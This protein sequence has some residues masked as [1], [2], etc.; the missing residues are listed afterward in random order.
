MSRSPLCQRFPFLGK[1][2]FLFPIIALGCQPAHSSYLPQLRTSIDPLPPVSIPPSCFGKAKATGDYRKLALIVGVGE[3]KKEGINDLRGPPNDARNIYNLLTR[4]TDKGGYGFPRENVCILLDEQAKTEDFKDAFEQGLIERVGSEKDVALFFYAG[5]GSQ[6]RDCNGDEPDEWDE[7]FMFH[8]ARSG[9]VKDFLDDEFNGLLARLYEKTHNITVILDS[10]N[11]GTAT[12][13]GNIVRRNQ[14]PDDQLACST[15]TAR[16]NGDGGREW[17]PDSFPGVVV[18]TAA[19]DGAQAIERRY[20]GQKGEDVFRGV[21]TDALITA[22]GHVD[23][24]PLTY[25]GIARRI[26]M[27][28]SAQSRQIPYFHGDLGKPV[29]GNTER[30]RPLGW[31]VTQVA[32]ENL[33]LSGPPLPGF[34]PGAELRV[35]DAAATGADTNDPTKLKAAIVIDNFNGINADARITSTIPVNGTVEVGD[36]AVLARVSNEE[37]K[38]SVRLRPLTE[39]NGI[40]MTDAER[41]RKTIEEDPEAAMLVTLA[42]AKGSDNFE[43]GRNIDGKWVLFG[44][45]NTVCRTF[46]HRWEIPRNLWQHARQKALKQLEGEGGDDF[47]DNET[48]RIKIA[49]AKTQ[50][51]CA[52]GMS[53]PPPILGKKGIPEQ[54]IPLCHRWH[55]EVT[56]DEQSPTPLLIGGLLLS[57]DGGI[58]GFPAD[59]REVR[60]RPGE[61]KRFNEGPR[62]TFIG[63]PPLEIQDQVMVFGSQERNPVKWHLL[64]D[65]ERKRSAKGVSSGLNK[66]LHRYLQAGKRGIGPDDG[67]YDPTTWTLSTVNIRVEANSRFLRPEWDNGDIDSREYAIAN[68]D[69][70]PYLP[71]DTGSALYKMLTKADELSRYAIANGVPY[72]QHSWNKSTDKE[73]LKVGIDCSRSIWYAFTRAG[74]L[75]NGDNEYLHTAMMSG[76]RSRMHEKF[77]ICS[78]DPHLRIG[79]VLIYRDK[80]RKIGHTVMVID[81]KKRIAWGARG[82][83]GNVREGTRES[84]TGVEYQLIKYKQDWERW[85]RGAMERVACWRYRDFIEQAK[86]GRGQPGVKALENACWC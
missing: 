45:E 1:L 47:D 61:T 79:D 66:V 2:L 29:F 46:R 41:L 34:G 69:I 42:D 86:A 7:T 20:K 38:I 70:R 33:E 15:D 40:P 39:P 43:I 23:N 62:E 54:I 4:E 6:I 49:S 64:A 82:W 10:C 50:K 11:S 26:P 31:D 77:E 84:D 53:L 68:F 55:V 51:P 83:D 85:N 37:L 67:P 27:R 22:L 35:Y 44:P 73:N 74:L 25:A 13:G 59:G 60:I 65:T 9:G 21:F 56:L 30:T 8:D 81:P 72:K 16:S 63:V 12:R 36:L 14:P 24:R 17:L 57:T 19:S 71:D 32:G 5:H 28:V 18:F 48:L 75:Y 80:K 3:Y 58:H 52:Q 76:P 78:N